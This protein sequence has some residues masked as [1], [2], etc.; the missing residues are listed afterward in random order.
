MIAALLLWTCSFH[1][2]SALNLLNCRLKPSVI[3][4]KL[5]VE[6]V[7]YGPCL[8]FSLEHIV[9][10]LRELLFTSFCIKWPWS[11]SGV[12]MSGQDRLGNRGSD[13]DTV[14]WSGRCRL[15]LLDL[16]LLERFQLCWLPSLSPNNIKGLVWLSCSIFLLGQFNRGVLRCASPLL[17]PRTSFLVYTR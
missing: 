10:W 11:T 6:I 2:F 12:A 4:L 8:I 1:Y 17:L 3:A 15:L 5:H 13:L 14:W 16:H 9:A 7:S